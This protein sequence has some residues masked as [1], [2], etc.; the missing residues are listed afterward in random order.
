M[1]RPCI[2]SIADIS[3]TS[4]SSPAKI[5]VLY[6]FP[7]LPIDAYNAVESI[8]S[9]VDSAEGRE[10]LGDRKTLLLLSDV[11]YYWKLDEV[12]EQLKQQLHSD[13]EVVNSHID[14]KAY[15]HAGGSSPEAVQQKPG[16]A[17]TSPPVKIAPP[18]TSNIS[19]DDS[20]APSSAEM[21]KKPSG[22]SRSRTPHPSKSQANAIPAPVAL[23]QGFCCA[24]LAS[25]KDGPTICGCQP[26]DAIAGCSANSGQSVSL[27][28]R[29]KT[30]APKISKVVEAAPP[31]ALVQGFCCAPLAGSG[32]GPRICGCK[33]E[34]S[35]AGCSANSGAAVSLKSRKS[36]PSTAESHTS[37]TPKANDPVP[38]PVALAQG[39]CCQPHAPDGQSICGCQASDKI[40]G[41][42]AHDA[43]AKPD[44]TGQ[45]PPESQHTPAEPTK[46]SCRTY[47]LPHG[48]SLARDCAII[49][50]GGESLAL[51][52]LLL[53]NAGVPIISYDPTGDKFA[54]LES[55][56]TNKM[57]MRRYGII[58]RA[59]DADVFGIV[60]GTL[61]AS[62]FL[63][64]LTYLRTLLKKHKKKSYTMA[65]GK[66]T[67]AKLANFLEVEA[68]V[69][70]ACSENSLVQGHKDFPK[71]I[72]TPWELEVALAEREWPSSQEDEKAGY[73]L[74]FEKVLKN[75]GDSLT[76]LNDTATP[77]SDVDDPEGPIFSTV[78]GQYRH[79]KTYN[80]KEDISDQHNLAEKVTT[81][82]I[83]NKE[84]AVSTALAAAGGECI[85][86]R[87]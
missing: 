39:F 87:N 35:I 14:A 72:I 9:F 11:R 27:K 28:T 56:K 12:Y 22:R 57:L 83:R 53:S 54:R 61:G 10:A 38:V 51:N 69:L 48:Q 19:G 3:I 71:P 82:A 41:C 68:W 23:V 31:V 6:V 67:P 75:A 64:T 15:L 70:V 24:P 84:T 44:E 50:I 43:P 13:Y 73:T 34:D 26:G 78:T 86:V 65:V 60:V 32:D 45:N 80:A 79:R 62:S 37:K 66:L 33:P 36:R 8:A 77:D 21:A 52:N 81:L 59:R 63:A 4:H 20:T 29:K 2:V 30:T 74:D 76:P 5:P 16:Q 40:P 7:K 47:S 49:Y 55:S 25:G 46:T 58:Q 17:T 18:A 42:T 85:A 1:S